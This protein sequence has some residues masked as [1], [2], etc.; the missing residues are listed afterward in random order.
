[1]QRLELSPIMSS[2][3]PTFAR[4]NCGF[5]CPCC[6]KVTEHVKEGR[7]LICDLKQGGCGHSVDLHLAGE[8]DSTRRQLWVNS[9]L[10]Y[11]RAIKTMIDYSLVEAIEWAD[12]RHSYTLNRVTR[13]LNR[14][15]KSKGAD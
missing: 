4:F 2:G 10:S 12:R 11:K 5:Y 9:Y 15:S 3:Y 6:S 7:S 8:F 14:L 13:Q 1:M